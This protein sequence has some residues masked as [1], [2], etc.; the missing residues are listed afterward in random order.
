M[1]TSG[2]PC[3]YCGKLFCTCGQ[4][5]MDTALHNSFSCIP[6][7]FVGI[8]DIIKTCIQHGKDGHS[9]RH[10][11]KATF[12]KGGCTGV[13]TLRG[14]SEA[15]VTPRDDTRG[16]TWEVMAHQAKHT[17]ST[18]GRGNAT[19]ENQI[20]L[21]YFLPATPGILSST[22]HRFDSIP[23]QTLPVCNVQHGGQARQMPLHAF[24]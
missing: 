23:E 19:E 21:A 5:H 16:Q 22:S 8:Y 24:V 15:V 13:R 11:R 1:N 18:Q 20:T 12:S 14:Y 17:G 10:G 2:R 4:D 9:D 7:Q 6:L 3:P